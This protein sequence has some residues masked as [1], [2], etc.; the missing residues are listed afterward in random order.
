MT[1][2]KEKFEKMRVAGNLAAR[3]LDMLTENIKEG[4]STDYIDKLG[5]EF[6]RDN[7]GY[8]A[9]L[10]YRGFT[11]SLCT[12][13]NHVV[14]HGIPSDR[15]LQEGDA[16]NVDVTAIVNEHYGDTSRMFCI[17]KTPV[18]LNNLIENKDEMNKYRGSTSLN[19]RKILS[20]DAFLETGYYDTKITEYLNKANNDS[21]PPKKKL[22]GG[23]LV[24]NLRYGENPHQGASVYSLNEEINVKQLNGKKLSYNNYNDIFTGISLSKSFT[25]NFSTVIIK[26]ANPCGVALDKRKINSYLKAYACDPTSAFGG[27]VSCNYKVDKTVAKEISSKFY[28]VVVANGFESG[29]LKIFKKKKN[30]RLIDSSLLKELN[31][32]QNTS[33]MNNFLS[34]TSDTGIFKKGDFK[35][36]SK[37]RPSKETLKNLLFTF[38]VCRFVK[39]NAIVISQNNSTIGIG[40]GQPSRLDS[41]KIAVSKMK[42][43]RKIDIKEKIVAASDAFFPFVDGI[44]TLVQAGVE[45]IIQPSGSIRDKEIINFANKTNT[46]LVFSMTRHFKH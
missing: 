43:L 46:I 20:R 21:P 6:I 40:S 28:E 23:N 24:E 10:Y 3:T 2:Y 36:V 34:P 16:V 38:N 35:V 29:A 18:K 1:D 39:S 25:K 19:F 30:L 13:L 33:I 11:K 45:A 44:E 37:V 14:C 12:S 17:G 4:I 26:H 8:S 42:K 32:E 7:G 5:Y 27:I 9:P 15:I 22:I 31:F 41:C